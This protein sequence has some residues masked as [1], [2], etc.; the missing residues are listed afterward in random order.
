MNTKLLQKQWAP[1]K[2][3]VSFRTIMRIISRPCEYLEEQPTAL[4]PSIELAADGP[5][6]QSVFLLTNTYICEARLSDASEAFDVALLRTIVYYRVDIGTHEVKPPEPSK[7]GEP[8]AKK[9]KTP[10]KNITYQTAKVSLGHSRA[11]MTSNMNYVGNDRETWL[12]NVR[13]VLPMNLLKEI[14]PI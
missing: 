12:R 11:G 3:L 13:S 14:T 9:E 7:S 6:L 5:V 8:T 1:H 10:P 4:I 2:S